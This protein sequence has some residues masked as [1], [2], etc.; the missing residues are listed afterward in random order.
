M[1]QEC[2]VCAEVAINQE[3]GLQEDRSESRRDSPLEAGFGGFTFQSL[4]PSPPPG[5]LAVLWIGMGRG[6]VVSCWH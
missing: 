3:W 5:P 2:P 4:P 6:L 1:A